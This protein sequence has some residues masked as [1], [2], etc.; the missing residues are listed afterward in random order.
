MNIHYT[1]VKKKL[2]K[3]KE[4]IVALFKFSFPASKMTMILKKLLDPNRSYFIERRPIFLAVYE[5]VN[6]IFCRPESADYAKGLRQRL[7]SSTSFSLSKN[8]CFLY[9]CG[10]FA[11]TLK[12]FAKYQIFSWKWF[13]SPEVES[14]FSSYIDSR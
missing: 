14:I 11:E 9:C 10:E 8:N 1:E 7:Y 12:Y 4:T 2:I 5:L 3:K 13:S 6:P